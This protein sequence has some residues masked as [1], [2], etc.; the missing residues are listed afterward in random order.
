[1]IPYIFLRAFVLFVKF[2]PF[3]LL[4]ICSDVLSFFLY[5]ILA[6]RKKVILGNLRKAFPEKSMI[7]LQLIL[8]HT[9]Q[10]LSDITLEGIKGM[11]A[12]HAELTKRYKFINPEIAS[13]IFKKGHSAIGLVA[14]YNN[15]E[16]GALA[17]A[18][19]IGG[20]VVGVSKSIRNVYINQYIKKNRARFGAQIIDMKTTARA[21]IENRGRPTLFVLI[22]DQSP[23]NS[24]T[25]HWLNF[26]N[27]DTA[28]LIGPDKIAQRT[29]YPV[30]YFDVKRI[31]RGYYEI[32]ATCLHPE[33]TNLPPGQ[34]TAMYMQK[35]EEVIIKK[36]ENWLWS[37]RRWKKKRS[38]H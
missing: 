38:L 17:T 26:L 36:P 28:C 6:Y 27:Q 3:S 33:P 34:I 7:D 23:S 15:W 20:Q 5:R 8:K 31:K 14:H 37:H 21:I 11:S 9:Y 22:A 2:I 19:Q 29:N 13:N 35:L 4:Y 32:E 30:L 24:K 1:M 10:N 12:S 16:W 25:A 18:S